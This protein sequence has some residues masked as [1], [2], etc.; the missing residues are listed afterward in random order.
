M[1]SRV[2]T[3]NT[4]QWPREDIGRLLTQSPDGQ[5]F[6]PLIALLPQTWPRAYSFGPVSFA[7][8]KD[9]RIIIP[10]VLLRVQTKLLYQ[11]DS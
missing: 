1:S 5:L 6:L 2:E 8:F 10:P 11:R 4:W 7:G 9:D 3:V